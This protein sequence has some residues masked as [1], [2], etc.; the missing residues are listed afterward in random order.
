[1]ALTLEEEFSEREGVA[2]IE[3]HDQAQAGTAFVMKTNSSLQFPKGRFPGVWCGQAAMPS[4]PPAVGWG[5]ELGKNIRFL[6]RDKDILIGQKRKGNIN[7]NSNNSNSRI[8]KT[9]AAQMQLLTTHLMMHNPFLSS[10][11]CPAFSRVYKLSM[12]TYSREYLLANC[13][14]LSWLCP[15]QDACALP[16]SSPV[17]KTLTV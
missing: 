1:M 14:Q 2:S 8:Y 13:G 16:A 12:M 9:S 15:L 6:G 4:C 7:N 10:G 5:R 17:G 3:L 11:S